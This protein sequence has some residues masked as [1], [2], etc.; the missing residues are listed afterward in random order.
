MT[1]GSYVVVKVCGSVSFSLLCVYVSLSLS[2][3]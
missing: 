3:I 1:F 2:I